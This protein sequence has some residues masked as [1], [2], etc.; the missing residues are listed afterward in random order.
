MTNREK[1][2][3]VYGFELDG[4]P[5][6]APQSICNEQTCERCPFWGWWDKE[7]KACFRYEEKKETKA[8]TRIE[9]EQAIMEKLGEIRKI[10]EEFAPENAPYL[11]MTLGKATP[12]QE[13]EGLW[14]GWRGSVTAFKDMD[15]ERIEYLL[16]A[17][18]FDG[19][20]FHH[21]DGT[22]IEGV[23]V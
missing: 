20:L 3:E 11:T 1:F 16:N 17:S 8:M 2:K 4:N 5:C 13:E 23:T 15:D 6:A 14:H 7:Y 22:I 21:D 12:E 18:V 9:C 10:Y 19:E